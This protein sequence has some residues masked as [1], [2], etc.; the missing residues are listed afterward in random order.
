MALYSLADWDRAAEMLDSIDW[1]SLLP[2]DVDSYWST[3]KNYFMQIMELCIPH[4]TAKIKTNPSWMNEE[5][6]SAIRKRDILFRTAKSSGKLSDREKYATKRNQVVDMVRRAKQT[7]FNDYLNGADVKTFWKTVRQLN[8]NTCTSS[9]PTLTSSTCIAHTSVAKATVLNNF[10][11]TCFNKDLPPLSN[12]QPEY[13]YN[14]LSPSGCPAAFLCVEESVQ[15]ML[16]QLD[17]SK[18]TG[19]DE[20]SPKM[21]K[22][23]SL[24]S[25]CTAKLLSNLFNLSISTGNFPSAWKVG[26]ITPIPKGTNNAHPSGYRPISVLPVVSKLIE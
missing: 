5:I 16:I 15:D 7:Y 14:S 12:S 21:L 23:A 11:Y 17:A 22:C 4:T 18:S 8:C 1:D 26:R 25:S 20:V 10:F 19:A 2:Q 6:R 9:I 13:A 3:L 24:A